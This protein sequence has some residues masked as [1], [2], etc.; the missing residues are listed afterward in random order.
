MSCITT[1]PPA[2]TANPTHRRSHAQSTGLTAGLFRGAG[3]GSGSGARTVVC[4]RSEATT[5][6]SGPAHSQGGSM[7]VGHYGVSFAAKKADDSIPLWVLF[8]AVQLLDVV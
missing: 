8:L 7:F 3:P 4:P 5:K 6:R 2:D 1:L